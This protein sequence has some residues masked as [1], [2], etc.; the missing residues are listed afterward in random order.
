MTSALEV[1]DS[2]SNKDE[3]IVSAA[4]AIGKSELR[5]RVFSAIYYHKK[6]FKS[7]SELVEYCN[8]SGP[9][10]DRIRV[11]QEALHLKKNKLVNKGKKDGEVAFGKIEFLDAHKKRI[12]RLAADKRARNN[13]RTKRNPRSDVNVSVSVKSKEN[14]VARSERI[15]IDDIGSFAKVRKIA[16]GKHISR[17]IS[18]TRF[19]RSIQRIIR[20]RSASNDWGGES[21]DVY[22]SNVVLRGRRVSTAFAFKGPGTKGKLTIAKM[23]KNGDQAKRLFEEPA[24]L[25]VVQ[26]CD[27]ITSTVINHVRLHADEKAKAIGKK[28]FYCIIDGADSERIRKA[29]VDKFKAPRK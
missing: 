20:D 4:E 14:R 22:T 16:P 7:L 11:N 6:Q 19:K 17:S 3:V 28:V 2:Q 1:V 12:L 24:D 9:R 26:Y 8:S 29:Y 10:V 5:Q 27:E 21:S 15:Y 13:V 25:F 23:G 18:E